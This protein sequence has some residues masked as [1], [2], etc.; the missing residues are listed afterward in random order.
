MSGGGADVSVDEDLY[1]RVQ[2]VL[3]ADAMKKLAT[4]RVL[5]VGLGGLGTEVAKNITL[6]GVGRVDVCD[7]K[8]VSYWDLGSLFFA[9][10]SDVGRPRL[11]VVVAPLQALNPNCPVTPLRSLPSL[12]EMKAYNV[13]VYCDQIDLASIAQDNATLREHGVKTVWAESRGVH[14]MLFSDMGPVHVVVDTTGTEAVRHAIIKL[15]GKTVTVDD[16]EP[17][18]LSTGDTVEIS[19]LHTTALHIESEEFRV[20]VTGS[21]SF[22]LLDNISLF[23]DPAKDRVITQGYIAEVK[24]PV[25][26]SFQSVSEALSCENPSISG[27]LMSDSGE[28][29]KA[30]S[31]LH[32][33]ERNNGGTLPEAFNQIHAEEI[34]AG[35][36]GGTDAETLA[37]LAA[38]SFNPLVCFMG[39]VAA[40]E[41][42]KGCSSKYCPVQQFYYLSAV[43][44]LP[45]GK[46]GAPPSK[47]QSRYA[48]LEA[49]IG[50]A[51]LTAVQDLRYFM[52]GCGAL[53]C[54]LLKNFAMLGIGSGKKGFLT[55]TDPDK[56]ERSNL[57]RQ[58][59]FRAEHVGG[60]KAKVGKDAVK[61]INP[62]V[63]VMAKTVK[64]CPETET[65]LEETFWKKQDGVVNALDNVKARLYVDG[66]CVQHSKPL[67][68]SGTLGPQ[69]HSQV[70]LPKLTE[71]YGAQRDPAEKNIPQ[72]T[73]H[74]FPNTVEHTIAFARD[75]FGGVF[76]S[77][78][79]AVDAFNSNPLAAEQKLA[80]LPPA[81]RLVEI[82][83]LH[84]CLAVASYEDCVR[85]AHAHFLH[86]FSHSIADI[87]RLHPLDKLDESGNDFWAGKFR[88]PHEIHFNSE[89]SSHVA[90]IAHIARLKAQLHN[91]PVREEDTA[92]L[93]KNLHSPVY[94]SAHEDE[95]KVLD[96]SGCTAK[97][98]DLVG[99]GQLSPLH[100]I[101]FE[102]DCPGNGHLPCITAV[103]N[104]R[105]R[106]YHIPT[107]TEQEV[108]RISGRIIPA[109]ITTTALITGLVCMEVLKAH[110][111]PALP[112][113]AFRNAWCNL[114]VPLMM[115]SCVEPP[116]SKPFLARENVTEAAVEADPPAWQH[117]KLYQKKWNVWERMEMQF[118]GDAPLGQLFS[119]FKQKYEV[120]VSQLVCNFFFLNKSSTK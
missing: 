89:D 37:S 101:E 44:C 98:A 19:G 70:I 49:V 35:S 100:A 42:L 67:F 29:H 10:E 99:A 17:L 115:Y 90:C 28:I 86:L 31:A 56:I 102:K 109:M 38:V 25:Q 46:P 27:D 63:K 111:T 45:K 26:M 7:D 79:A 94:T 50:K 60:F 112:L 71:N 120:E 73:L 77:A 21:H 9:Q 8:A 33:W 75:W 36:G 51:N 83:L 53:G 88:P 68:D 103:A 39:G 117:H 22:E 4:S 6:T 85:W 55:V 114:A 2:Y 32:A 1:S 78:A 58:F 95:R 14:G 12:E 93:C 62:A 110:Y 59:L 61:A 30:F 5:I 57:S 113:D 24:Q 81:A 13:V 106:C 82:K 72:C 104:L 34:M 118:K 96:E 3:G 92:V 15:E 69:A 97:W 23:F 76:E 47:P 64:V 119:S 54:E 105:A 66:R 16:E 48:S 40:Q 107:A 11:D 116:A 52:V 87:L 91:I 65:Q 20:K 74:F 18:G 108:K 41:V 84:D 43:H 80:A